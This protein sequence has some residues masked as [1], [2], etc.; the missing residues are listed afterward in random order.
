[1]D[2]QI[3]NKQ[4]KL[5]KTST[6]VHV[7]R[8]DQP[9][10]SN[11]AGT[12]DEVLCYFWTEHYNADCKM[13]IRLNFCT[14][15]DALD[16]AQYLCDQNIC[17][18][19]INDIP[20]VIPPTAIISLNKAENI[21]ELRYYDDDNLQIDDPVNYPFQRCTARNFLEAVCDELIGMGRIKSY[22]IDYGE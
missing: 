16:H 8:Y 12:F 21:W 11:T 9:I 22:S 5:D 20:A 2:L 4:F 3:P 17:T 19:I 18:T 1:M 13:N 6:P 14:E 10:Y 7:G 15:T